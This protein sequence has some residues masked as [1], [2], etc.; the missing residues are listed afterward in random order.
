MNNMLSS[1]FRR[2]QGVVKPNDCRSPMGAFA[3]REGFDI[4][5]NLNW[6]QG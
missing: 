3:D 6:N 4:Q 1:Y 5:G 2:G